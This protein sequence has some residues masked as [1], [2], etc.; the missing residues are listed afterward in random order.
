MITADQ[1]KKLRHNAFMIKRANFYSKAL[2]IIAKHIQ[3]ALKQ[4]KTGFTYYHMLKNQW[5]YDIMTDILGDY[6]DIGY[7]YELSETPTEATYKIVVKF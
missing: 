4:N 7:Q 6:A 3:K 1:A 5:Q 2:H